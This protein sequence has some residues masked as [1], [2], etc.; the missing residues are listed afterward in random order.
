M[1]LNVVRTL[2]IYKALA[3]QPLIAGVASDVWKCWVELS[4]LGIRGGGESRERSIQ[5]FGP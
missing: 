2:Q 1:C 3:S 5:E 4:A